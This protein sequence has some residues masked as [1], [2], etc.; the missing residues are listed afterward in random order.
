MVD[1]AL[2]KCM[3]F[4]DLEFVWK[5]GPIIDPVARANVQK[6][7]VDAKVL[8]PDEVR[9]DIGR[10]PLT[11]VQKAD[12]NPPPPPMLAGPGGPDGEQPPKPG[13]PKAKEPAKAPP[14]AK[15][16]A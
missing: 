14:A 1:T 2:V 3:G 7:Y 10:D 15:E 4:A 13:E 12:L 5:E 16:E 9:A 8:H 6:V 11:P